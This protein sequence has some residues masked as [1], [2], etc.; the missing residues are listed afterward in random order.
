[1]KG[2]SHDC[3]QQRPSS[4]DKRLPLEV[5]AGLHEFKGPIPGDRSS[6]SEAPVLHVSVLFV[7]GELYRSDSV[8]FLTIPST[9]SICFSADMTFFTESS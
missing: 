4:G 7:N 9:L 8:R 5:R 6:D 3:A 1:M 2:K